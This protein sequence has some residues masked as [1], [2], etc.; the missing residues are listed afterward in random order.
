[1][2]VHEHVRLAA[3]LRQLRER[4]QRNLHQV[5][6]STDVE[7]DAIRAFVDDLSSQKCNQGRAPVYAWQSAMASASDASGR[8]ALCNPQAAR[9]IALTSGLLARP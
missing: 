1:M 8:G 9:T 4:V 6:H 5:S 3:G 7:H 2:R